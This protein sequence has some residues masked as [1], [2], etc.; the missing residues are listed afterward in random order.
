MTSFVGIKEAFNDLKNTI[1]AD[2][3]RFI[4]NHHAG[5]IPARL[6]ATPHIG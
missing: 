4:N 5:N 1:R 3:R 2:T 6:S